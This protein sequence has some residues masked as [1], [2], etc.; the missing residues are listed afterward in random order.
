[1][2]ILILVGRVLFSVIFLMAFFGHFKA[3]TIAYAK[4]VGLPAA[5]VLVPASGVV[6]GLGALSVMLGS[7]GPF[8]SVDADLSNLCK[9]QWPVT[10]I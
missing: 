9:S 10:V 8:N 2:S 1:M 5:S 7:L 3:G 4:Q 6:A